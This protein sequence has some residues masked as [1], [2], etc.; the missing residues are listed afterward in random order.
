M[1]K[2]TDAQMDKAKRMFF[3]ER[4]QE[5]VKIMTLTQADADCLGVPL[6]ELK[7][8]ETFRAIDRVARE[9][10]RDTAELM[11][12]LGAADIH[13]YHRLMAARQEEID[14]ALGM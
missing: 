14:K 6:D 9:N 7:E 5:L 2:L 1:P 3:A 4:P 10:G 8:V 11:F 12:N 13:E